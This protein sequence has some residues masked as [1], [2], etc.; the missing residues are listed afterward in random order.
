MSRAETIAATCARLGYSF[1]HAPRANPR[2]S[3]YEPWRLVSPRGNTVARA[4]SRDS[5]ESAAARY[6]DRLEREGA[7]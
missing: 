4:P 2:A 7:K 6:F 1:E 5:L 3:L